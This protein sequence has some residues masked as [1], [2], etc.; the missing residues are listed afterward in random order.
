MAATVELSLILDP[1]GNKFKKIFSSG[2]TSSVGTKLG[3]LSLGELL[4]ELYLSI[5]WMLTK[6]AATA[7]CHICLGNCIPGERLQAI[8]YL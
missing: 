3:K 8:L 4:S 2:T 1:M 7:I 5:Q 6:I